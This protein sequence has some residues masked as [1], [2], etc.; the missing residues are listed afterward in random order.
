MTDLRISSNNWS[1]DMNGERTYQNIDGTFIAQC[2]EWLDREKKR[3]HGLE[4]AT[5]ALEAPNLPP[6]PHIDDHPVITID[7][8]I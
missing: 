7:V 5:L 1:S 8:T 6:M 2:P 4:T 3:F